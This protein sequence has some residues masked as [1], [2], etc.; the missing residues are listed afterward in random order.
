MVCPKGAYRVLSQV[1][2]LVQ[3]SKKR[4]CDNCIKKIVTA[5]TDPPTHHATGKLY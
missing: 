1:G 5:E 2:E 4:Y 3:I